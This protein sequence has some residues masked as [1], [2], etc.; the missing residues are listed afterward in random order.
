MRLVAPLGH[1]GWGNIGD[2]A[3]LQGFA[4]L[5]RHGQTPAAVWVASHNPAHTARVEPAFRYFNPSGEDPRR[6][7]AQVLASAQA[8]V[9]GTPVMDVLGKWPLSELAPLVHSVVDR[10]KIPLA[11]IGI[12]T[13]SLRSKESRRIVAEEIAPRVRHWSVRSDRDRQR[14]T[15]YGVSGDA[16]TVAADMAW[17]LEP[18]TPDSGEH[19][20]RKWG[21]NARQPLIGVNL[22]NENSIFDQRPQ[23]IDALALALDELCLHTKARVIFLS[24]EIR[25]D[26]TFDKAAALKVIGRMKRA[27]RTLLAANKYFTPQEMMSLIGSC[28]VTISMRY[29][30]CLFSALQGVPFVAVERSD[31]VADLSWDLG[32]PAT[33]SPL[34]LEA[35][36]LI[37]HVRGFTENAVGV[38]AHLSRNVLKMKARAL[39]N[40]VALKSLESGRPLEVLRRIKI[41][42]GPL[43][44]KL[45]SRG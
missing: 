8:I 16:I 37:E 13:E 6:W 31:K 25:E 3:T 12:G 14:L 36:R 5:L 33:I 29:H 24:N 42:A 40:L 27:D 10:W 22:V 4:R 20:L 34:Q 7:L 43:L 19:W 15:E 9:G 2:E 35:N 44:G 17:L 26:A 30:F 38:R 23:L 21:A 41:A 28:D 39:D 1:F 32:W 11:F 45:I 18:V